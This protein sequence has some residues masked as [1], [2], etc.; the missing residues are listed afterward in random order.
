MKCDLCGIPVLVV[1]I[2]VRAVLAAAPHDGGLPPRDRDVTGSTVNKAEPRVFALHFHCT[3]LGS[4]TS[5]SAE[6]T[7]VGFSNDKTTP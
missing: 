6:P 2:F 5:M 1:D 4:G 7:K 3:W